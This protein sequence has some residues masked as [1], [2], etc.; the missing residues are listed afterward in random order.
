M[1]LISLKSIR[2]MLDECAPGYRMEL[3]THNWFVYFS[4]RTYPS[5]PK[6]DEIEEFHVRKLGRTL[7]IT[8][9]LKKFFGW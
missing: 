2:E 6:Y 4:G 8:E 9:C 3:K 7:Q 1:A 5:L